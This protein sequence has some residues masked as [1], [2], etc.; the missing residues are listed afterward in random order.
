MIRAIYLNGYTNDISAC[1]DVRK[2]VY[3]KEY[4]EDAERDDRDR[5]AVHILLFDQDDNPIG[6]A[7]LLFSMDERFEF[8][9]LSVIEEARNEGNGDFIMHLIFDKAALSGAKYLVSS[10]TDHRKEYFDRYGFEE[11]DGKLVLDLKKYYKEH[12]CH[13]TEQ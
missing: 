4:G 12:S 13:H 2:A 6:T 3:D 11:I 8:G 1:I 7:R 9:Y 5:D 10:E